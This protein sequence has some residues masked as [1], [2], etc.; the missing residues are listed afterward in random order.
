MKK[1]LLFLA[2][3]LLPMVFSCGS[4]EESAS[5]SELLQ[6][7]I[8]SWMCTQ[9]TDIAQGQ[10]YEGLL[11]GAMVYIQKNGTYTSTSKTFGTSGTYT[12]SG[13][14]ITAKSKSGD[15]FLVTVTINGDNMTWNGTSSTGVTFT[16]L[17]KRTIDE[18][19]VTP[20]SYN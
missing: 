10:K 9:S 5:G 6:K 17:F 8:G 7:A 18:G 12:I 2:L 14:T 1:I 16:Y 15:T 11:V 3:M 13:N 20:P 4:D 19:S